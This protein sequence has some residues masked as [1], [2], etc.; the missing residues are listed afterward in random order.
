MGR[1]KMKILNLYFK[2]I[3]S[4]VGEQRLDFARPPL[5]NASVFA[6]TGPNGSGKSTLLDVISL[7]LFGETYRFDKPAE[8]VMSKQT[9]ECF[10]QVDFSLSGQVYRA[11][12]SARRQDDRVDG[13]LLPAE[14]KLFQ[15]SGEN[16]E[17]LADDLQQVRRKMIELTSLDLHKFNQTMV[18]AQGEFAAFLNALDTER[19]DILEKIIGEDIYQKKRDEIQQKH[20]Q[21]EQQ[22][23]LLQQDLSAIPVLA[24]AEIEASEHDLDDFKEQQQQYQTQQNAIERRLEQARSLAQ[25][26]T[27]LKTLEQNKQLL[28]AACEAQ[29]HALKEAEALQF[30]G[31]FKDELAAYQ[32]QQ[33]QVEQSQLQ[34]KR[35]Q[36]EIDA[37]Q[38]Q[39]PNA[40]KLAIKQVDD[41]EIARQQQVIEEIRRQ[42]STLRRE[43]PQETSLL[44]SVTT[45]LAEKKSALEFTQKWLQEHQQDQSLLDNFP[46]IGKLKSVRGDIAKLEENQKKHAKWTKSTTSA[47]K[48]Q[49]TL[50]K[51]KKRTI[52]QLQQK[53]QETEQ[54]IKDITHG[55][56]F[57]ELEA[58]KLEQQERVDDFIELYDLAKV[59]AKLNKKGIFA[60]FAERKQEK[61]DIDEQALEEE[62][63]LLELE[64]VKEENILGMLE[65]AVEYEALLKRME[66]YRDKLE[67]G[68]PCP[69]C[70]SIHHPYAERPPRIEDS[71]KALADQKLK[72][73]ALKTRQVGLKLQ[74]KEAQ[75]L[76]G[77]QAHKD[78]RLEV[79]VSQWKA[80]ANRLNIGSRVNIDN[81][82]S[83]KAELKKEKE[84]LAEINKLI[85]RCAKLHNQVEQIKSN[86]ELNEKTLERARQE[87][88]KLN[89]EWNNRPREL[90]EMEKMLEQRKAEEKALLRQ[91]AEQLGQVAEKLPESGE[92]EACFERLNQR[93][94]EYQTRQARARVLSDDIA[95]LEEKRLFCQED[96]DALNKKLTQCTQQLNEE[97]SVG[98]QLAIV[99][100]QKLLAD[101][102]RQLQQQQQLFQ[103]MQQQLTGQIKQTALQNIDE[104]SSAIQ[105]VEQLPALKQQLQQQQQELAQLE[106]RQSAL[107]EQLEQQK[108]QL[109]DASSVEGL[110]QEL[111]QIQEK[112][113]IV[114]QE[115]STVENKLNKH[116]AAQEKRIL[117][118]EKLQQHQL[119]LKQSEQELALAQDD[120]GMA[121]RRQV[122]QMLIDKM[123]S[124][125]NRILE[126]ISGRYY[127]RHMPTE[128]GFAM[129]IED[130]R[131]NN[132]RRLP[133]T[134]SGGE[135][136]V[137]S[138][139][140]ALS[141]AESADQGHAIDSL[142]IDEGFG[143][144]DKDSLYLV[145]STLENLKTQG[146]TVGVISHVEA[147]KKR[148]KTRI[149]MQKNKDGRSSFKVVG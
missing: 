106:Q 1:Y 22:V 102:E 96:V 141:L 81:P 137:V 80:L 138:L 35:F 16:L 58:L 52:K 42:V 53:L 130:A 14:M 85:R 103:Q 49:Q 121:F 71:K 95:G 88:E 24:E 82:A 27:E 98:L 15:V 20:Q 46:E 129:L 45:Q 107:A 90:V 70:G 19:M 37:L 83:V 30:A 114:R 132:S 123:L 75:K 65:K 117:I 128:Q 28:E 119:Q 11:L 4:L 136:F 47:L 111:K 26:E 74:L 145:M 78:E 146:K 142:F 59:N 73:K 2:N 143:N 101:K 120:K 115:I 25:L 10:A 54:T 5:A 67:E 43:L 149:E 9:A 92:E 139:A 29:Q 72:I 57:E 17:L 76:Q 34:L 147:V 56:S 148:V 48:K 134:L 110:A 33:Q 21:I 109:S 124:K 51:D 89:A 38:K 125:S 131:Q 60:F 135:S 7:A 13:E 66:K 77:E 94:M 63:H 126:K 8:H 91:V 23:K 113:D 122:Q 36:D 99:E 31:A 104:L 12:W 118:E 79:V 97:E 44:Q 62:V 50:V 93:R 133:K 105:K 100:K 144:L 40:E 6:I 3:K 86:L 68:K 108:D 41:K 84:Q 112:A 32:Q 18:L 61:L 116:Q 87:Y 64:I 127:L 55:K 69:L 140:L 39:L